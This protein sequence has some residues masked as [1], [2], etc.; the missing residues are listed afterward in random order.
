[1]EIFS[2]EKNKHLM[3]IIRKKRKRIGMT[4]EQACKIIDCNQ[5]QYSKKELGTCPTSVEEFLLLCEA[6]GLTLECHDRASETTL[7]VRLEPCLVHKR[8][9]L[10]LNR[11]GGGG[12]DLENVTVKDTGSGANGQE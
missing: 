9:Q 8:S 4:Q 2:Q 5:S 6:F 1:M 7:E 10:V 12:H 3:R 11:N